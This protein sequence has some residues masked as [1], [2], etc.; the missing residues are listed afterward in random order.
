MDD[1]FIVE[2]AAEGEKKFGFEVPLAMTLSDALT[3]LK[4]TVEEVISASDGWK[5]QDGLKSL[6]VVEASAW[7]EIFKQAMQV[8]AA[9]P[10]SPVAT[11][12]EGN[13]DKLIGLANSGNKLM[14]HFYIYG[15]PG[16]DALKMYF[17]F[18]TAPG[19]K[20]VTSI[21]FG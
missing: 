11:L 17:V 20:M 8:A 14:K 12:S 7:L 5:D 13:A 16:S 1:N 4:G 10:L 18:K 2:L 15:Q 6:I 21:D 3:N 19:V 9:D